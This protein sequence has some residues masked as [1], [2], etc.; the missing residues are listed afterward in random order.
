MPA[1]PKSRRCA[2]CDISWPTALRFKDCPRCEQP[3][4]TCTITSPDDNIIAANAKHE[5]WEK[6]HERERAE[7]KRFVDAIE[8]LEEQFGA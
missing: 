5:S 4:E 1:D 3:T 2:G 8:A 6:W 7:R